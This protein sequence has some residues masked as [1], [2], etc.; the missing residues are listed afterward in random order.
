MRTKNLH[1]SSNGIGPT[2][3]GSDMIGSEVAVDK[4]AE[5]L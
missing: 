5:S 3:S 4:S 1:E 2:I